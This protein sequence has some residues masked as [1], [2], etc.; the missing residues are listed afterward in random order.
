M[1]MLLVAGMLM[2]GSASAS[3]VQMYTPG[4]APCAGACEQGW[5]ESRFGVPHGEPKRMTI[6]AGSMVVQMSYAKDGVPYAVNMS[7]MLAEDE[8]GEGYA[9]ERDGVTFWMVKLDVCQNWAVMLPPVVW[10]SPEPAG[11]TL[12]QPWTP[13]V[14]G[15]GGGIVHTPPGPP[16]IVV[17]PPPVAAVPLGQ[18]ILMLMSALGGLMLMKGKKHV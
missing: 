7:A 6:P 5:A 4:G 13:V 17:E 15:G 12:R 1:K 11:D 9:F 18:S 10:D 2:A 3:T 14:W 8:P 16:P